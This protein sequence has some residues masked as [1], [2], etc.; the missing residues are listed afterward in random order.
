[1][2][3]KLVL[4]AALS[5]LA[6]PAVGIAQANAQATAPKMT[7]AQMALASKV[8]LGEAG[9]IALKAVPGALAEIGFNDENGTGVYEASVVGRDGGVT[10]V[11]VDAQTGKVL[12]T[13]KQ[14]SLGDET[15]HEPGQ[16]VEG[17]DQTDHDGQTGGGEEQEG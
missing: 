15:D 9:Q 6:L 8:K 16:Q 17:G 11:K 2:K 3:R 7:E 12:G 1:M 13:A 14:A 5:G 10:V 4:A